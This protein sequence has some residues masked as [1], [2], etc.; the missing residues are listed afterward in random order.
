MKEIIV[1]K[2]YSSDLKESNEASAVYIALRGMF[3]NYHTSEQIITLDSIIY[4]LTGEYNSENA[5]EWNKRLKTSI[6][7]GLDELQKLNLIKVID[8]GKG[9]YIVDAE[10]LSYINTTMGEESFEYI[11]LEEV[12]NIFKECGI[13]VFGFIMS[14]YDE[15]ENMFYIAE[16]QDVMLD[17]F[18]LNSRTFNKYIKSLEENNVIYV[19]RYE[20]KFTN[21]GLNACNVYGCNNDKSIEVI[22]EHADKYIK[23]N[24]MVYSGKP[25]YIPNKVEQVEKIE[26]TKTINV[27]NHGDELPFE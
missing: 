4:I 15:L 27:E 2:K 1:S 11:S 21:S 25:R 18:N 7:K 24:D 26:I 6:K 16:K 20:H 3:N 23:D 13:K 12:R 22:N 10:E 19:Y 17:I 14:F 5:R 9:S 8:I